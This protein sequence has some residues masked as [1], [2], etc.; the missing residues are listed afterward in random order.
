MEASIWKRGRALWDA[1]EWRHIVLF[2]GLWAFLASGAI[3]KAYTKGE[4]GLTTFGYDIM[5]TFI[6]STFLMGIF[7]VRMFWGMG[8][9]S[10]RKMFRLMLKGSVVFALIFT[11][12]VYLAILYASE[13][14]LEEGEETPTVPE[15]NE[16]V[17][18]LVGIFIGGYVAGLLIFLLGYVMCMGLVGMVYLSTVG[19]APP[20][21]R[22][23]RNLTAGDKW[24]GS[25][26][27]WLFFI[28]DNLD[29]GTLKAT[30][31]V[32]E[33]KFPWTRFK[34]AVAW[35]TVFALLIAILVSLNPFLL[36][37][38]TI[39]TLFTIMNNAHVIVPML[40]LPVLVVLRLRVKIDAPVKD[41]YIY[42]GIRTRLVRTF[43]AI[44]TLVLF[45]RL[46]LKDL[47]PEM[48]VLNLM[49]YFFIAITIISAFT[50]L[51][52][53]FVENHL[54]FRVIERASW[55]VDDDD[56]DEADEADGD[57]GEGDEDVP[58]EM[59]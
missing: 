35:Q 1:D 34:R 27:E 37:V 46:A 41:F 43:L 44:G 17:I 20:F 52:F 2:L 55:L 31:P 59:P 14:D 54:A 47:D 12:I 6:W 19:F 22:R 15:G 13:M 4:W 8:I 26:L 36:D 28:P 11:V 48:V 25:A 23:V 9:I 57:P 7:F 38:V 33:E 50:W 18:A 56:V 21:L 45:V 29:T 30:A 49:G 16:I 5:I 51:Y 53:N 3:Y 58:E 39:E 40:F 10:F 42:V 24:Y 32:V